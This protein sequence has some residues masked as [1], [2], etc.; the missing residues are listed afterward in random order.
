M[1]TIF[2]LITLGKPEKVVVHGPTKLKYN[3]HGEFQCV[4]HPQYINPKP[5]ISWRIQM[6]TTTENLMGSDSLTED[7]LS[8]SSLYISPET[9]IRDYKKNAHHDL[10]VE[11]LFSHPELGDDFVS[12]THMVEVL[13]KSANL[14][15]NFFKI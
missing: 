9:A 10:V 13:C 14:L 1:K 7:N 2:T 6:G 5:K 4:A 15:A 8:Q 12:Y 11:C 3:E